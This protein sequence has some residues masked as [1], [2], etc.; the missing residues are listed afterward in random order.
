MSEFRLEIFLELMELIENAFIF[1]LKK[2]NPNIS[3]EEISTEIE[4]W[5][6]DKPK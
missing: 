2:K 6:K 1:K 4:S 3:E 5:Y